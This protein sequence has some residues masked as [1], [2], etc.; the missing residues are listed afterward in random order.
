MLL[1]C[2]KNKTKVDSLAIQTDQNSNTWQV[3]CAMPTCS[4]KKMCGKTENLF[5]FNFLGTQC[6]SG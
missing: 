5:W 1:K 4:M 3:F 2:C 6:C